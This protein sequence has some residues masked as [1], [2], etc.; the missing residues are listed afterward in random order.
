MNIDVN[1]IYGRSEE[2][3]SREIEGECVLI[4]V[5]SGIGETDSEIFTLNN[6]GKAI[7]N[8]IDGKKTLR[9]IA[10]ALN[11]EFSGDAG[12]I[13]RDVAGMAEEFL[14]RKMIADIEK[15]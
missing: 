13:E 12:E 7:W 5:A 14:K 11:T 3:I 2:V 10:K 15:D 8:N 1:K 4:P 6:T 9:D